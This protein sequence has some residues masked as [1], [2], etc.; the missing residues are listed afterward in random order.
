MKKA[1][2]LISIIAIGFIAHAEQDTTRNALKLIAEELNISEQH[3]FDTLV[4]QQ[5][6]ISYRNLLTMIT[7]LFS[8]F[9]MGKYL[10]LTFK[11][12]NRVTY[13]NNYNQE[14]TTVSARY[15]IPLVMFML[16]FITGF[17][18]NTVELQHTITGLFNPEY[19]AL[20]QLN[21]LSK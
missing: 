18:Y 5:K 14:A 12:G 13:T 8:G 9:F 1:L 11:E 4:Q 21:F 17:I 15:V 3:A 10:K 20:E 2:L 7:I 19:G 6:I 16:I